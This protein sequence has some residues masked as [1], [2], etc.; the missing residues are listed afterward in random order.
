MLIYRRA[1]RQHRK[2]WSD[3]ARV[4]VGDA[5]AA[6][7]VDGDTVVAAD[8]DRVERRE[9]LRRV[10][11]RQLD[12]FEQ[13]SQLAVPVQA[14]RGLSECDLAAQPGA[15]RHDQLVVAREDRLRDDRF[16]RRTA[17]RFGRI[18]RV[19]QACGQDAVGRW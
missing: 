5:R 18:E 6:F 19:H 12:A 16:D 14:P 1:Q 2:H 17:R 8:V 11:I 7:L 9:E 13:E 15:F 10:L 4:R 3:E